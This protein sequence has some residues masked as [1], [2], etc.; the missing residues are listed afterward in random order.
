MIRCWSI[1]LAVSWLAGVA[2]SAW[3]QAPEPP[4][5]TDWGEIR[6]TDRGLALH[7]ADARLPTSGSVRTPRLNN[8]VAAIY[9]EGDK[10]RA[11]L[12]LTPHVAEWEIALPVGPGRFGR[13]VV[14]VE[15]VGPPRWTGEP[16]IVGPSASGRITLAAHDAV[17]HGQNLR[18]EPQ[19]H[20]NTVGYWSR[21]EDWCEW[22][23]AVTRPGRY[24][25]EILQGC[26][27]GH[28][29]SEVA[30]VVGGQEIVFTV[31]ETGHFQ[32]FKN[33]TLGTI[34]LAAGE[35]QTLQLRPRSKKAGAV[36]DV[37]QVRLIPVAD[38]P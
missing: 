18:Y 31:E 16:R 7:I 21:Q 27:Q 13:L 29:G 24:E 12:K 11:P 25:I 20:K 28:G 10:D 15:T 1:G 38:A 22:H 30:L 14:V 37:R 6:S 32:N 2:I 33:R 26:G 36:M 9:V 5:A 17:T 35:D 3:A 19:P 23:F 34:E 4:I 8:P